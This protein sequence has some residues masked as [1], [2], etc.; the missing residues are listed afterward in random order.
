MRIAAPVVPYNA[1]MA[2]PLA[3]TRVV[4]LGDGVSAAAAARWLADL[5]AEV[6]KVEAPGGDS[7]R[8]RGPFPQRTPDP[9]R[10]GLFLGLNAGKRS[11]VLDLDVPGDREQLADLLASS[12]ALV[13]NLA[14]ARA[15][16]LGLDGASLRA[17]HPHL[18]A[19]SVTPF[20][21][22]G[23]YRD[24]RAEELTTT[25][26]GG[27]CWL[28]PGALAEAERP[29]LKTAGHQADLHAALAAATATLAALWRARRGGGGEA[30]DVAGREAVAAILEVGLIGFTYSGLVATRHGVRGL[31]PWGIFECSDGRIFL[32]TIEDD[33]WERLVAFMGHP[34]WAELEIFADFPARARNADAL[35]TF[36]Q[37]WISPWK[38]DELFHEGQRRRICFAPVLDMAG[39]ATAP[40]LVERGFFET[41][42]APGFGEIRLPGHPARWSDGAAALRGPAPR[43]DELGRAPAAPPVPAPDPAATRTGRPLEG[44]RVADFSW[45]W[46]GPFGAMQLAH[47]GA[48]VIKLESPTRTDIGRRLPVFH[49]DHEPGLDRSGYFNQWN[50]G[51]QSVEL[52]LAHAEAAALVKELVAECDVVVENFATGVMDRNGIGWEALRR[53][54]P[55]LVFASIS[56][57]G[58]SGPLADYMGYGPAMGPLS[59]LSH[60]TGYLGGPPQ[61]TGISVGDPVAGMTAAMAICAA[62]VE[63]ERTGRGRFLDISLWESTVAMALE[64]WLPYVVNGDEPERI[65]N[66]D[67]WMAPHGL[68]PCAGNDAWVSIA[69]R[70]DA[71]WRAL[72]GCIGGGLADDARFAT[73]ADRKRNET[74][75]EEIV[76]GFTR[77]RDRW[78]ITRALQAVG[79]AAFPSL[80]PED[81]ARDPQFA[82]RGFLERL[83]HP[84]VGAM[85]H[86]GIPWRLTSGPNGVRAPAP[87]LGQHTEAVLGGLLGYDA[88]AIAAMRAR[89]LLG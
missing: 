78:E 5:G 21:A 87:L 51:K 52:N 7:T 69:C 75:L 3:G 40:H 55:R 77:G 65:G 22:T 63:R 30:I 4:E 47:L 79:V 64:A 66:R 1:R 85:T 76:G 11:L 70:D 68:F 25:N 39:V 41:L 42:K 23:P 81:L 43:L 71:A 8:M 38:V 74:A 33:Q 67:P 61:E 31:N 18:V 56:G 46:A 34:D 16:R 14:P 24:Y 53:V 50:Q 35:A 58:G 80:T 19:T 36:V 12:H 6:I 83:E 82:A 60:A 44:I 49:P 10:S 45:V 57:Y 88:E 20:G 27:W 28:S 84:E 86:A 72:A 15:E 59:G 2:A 13:H 73:A 54:N 62:L 9:E 32:A 29:P 48:E 89:G 17:R 37:E 26:A